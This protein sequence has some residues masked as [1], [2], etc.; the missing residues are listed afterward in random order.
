MQSLILSSEVKGFAE[1][2]KQNNQIFQIFNG[3]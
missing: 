3:L 2:E 1:K